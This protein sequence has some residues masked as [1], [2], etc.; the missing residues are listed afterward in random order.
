MKNYTQEAT[1]DVIH[2]LSKTDL[3]EAHPADEGEYT[4]TTIN[5]NHVLFTVHRM[6][7]GTCHIQTA[8]VTHKYYQHNDK[9][10]LLVSCLESY[11]S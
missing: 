3:S 2:H 1:L 8:M 10:F 9:M 7:N 11:E 4:F 6:E 5:H